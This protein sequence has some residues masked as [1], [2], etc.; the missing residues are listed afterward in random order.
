VRQRGRARGRQ[1]GGARDGVEGEVGGACLWRD[2]GGEGAA[3]S[4]GEY[5]GDFGGQAARAM[6][7]ASPVYKGRSRALLDSPKAAGTVT[8]VERL[9]SVGCPHVLLQLQSKC[10]GS[11]PR[12]PMPIR[13][14]LPRPGKHTRQNTREARCS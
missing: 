7:E 6:A 3:N 4:G 10:G 11:S 12:Q 9:T 13:D 14:S 5:H 2:G 8:V 1:A